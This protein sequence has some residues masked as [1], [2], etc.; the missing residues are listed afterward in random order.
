[1]GIA[2]SALAHFA[3][4]LA[5]HKLLDLGRGPGLRRGGDP[6]LAPAL[7]GLAGVESVLVVVMGG[8]AREEVVQVVVGVGLGVAGQEGVEVVI[9]VGI[10]VAGLENVVVVGKLGPAGDEGFGEVGIGS[11]TAGELVD[12]AAGVG[13]AG[14]EAVVAPVSECEPGDEDGGD[15]KN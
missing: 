2:Q 10:G 9:L 6:A 7:A 3:A 4:D 14:V 8:V 11:R 5:P 1:M 12:H 13:I 15:G